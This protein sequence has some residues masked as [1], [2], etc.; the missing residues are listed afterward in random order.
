MAPF[1]P[2]IRSEAPNLKTGRAVTAFIGWPTVEAI[3][4]EKPYG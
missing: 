2:L 4:V 3:D 1:A